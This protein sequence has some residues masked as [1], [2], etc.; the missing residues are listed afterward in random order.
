MNNFT[1]IFKRTLIARCY[2]CP[3]L[4]M[5]LRLRKV[6]SPGLGSYHQFLSEAE[7]LFVPV[8]LTLMERKIQRVKRLAFLRTHFKE[9]RHLIIKMFEVTSSF[10]PLVSPFHGLL[11][12]SSLCWHVFCSVRTQEKDQRYPNAILYLRHSKIST[13]FS[14]VHPHRNF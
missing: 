2:Y 1:E 10:P 6:Q 5:K 4:Q 13:R 12:I 14:V 7:P 11:G 9:V 3:T 8:P